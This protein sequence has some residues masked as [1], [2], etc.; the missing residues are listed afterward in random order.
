[1]PATDSVAALAVAVR[2]SS[3]LTEVR[4]DEGGEPTTAS[5][6]IASFPRDAGDKEAL[7]R[8]ADTAL[9]WAKDHGRDRA[10]VFDPEI[11][12]ADGPRDRLR[13]LEEESSAADRP[14][15]GRRG[16]RA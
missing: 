6:G 12:D 5:V 14:Y 11:G 3:G 9:Y 1:M 16:R 13:R 10:M 7:L 4:Y 8:A 15:S 2:I